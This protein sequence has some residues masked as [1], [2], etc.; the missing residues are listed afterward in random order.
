MENFNKN[1]SNFFYDLLTEEMENIRNV[2]NNADVIGLKW[3]L[4]Q[5]TANS[6][7][8]NNCIM[9]LTLLILGLSII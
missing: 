9:Q 5:Y 1:T 2:Q 6:F 3:C 4:Y 8:Y 7:L